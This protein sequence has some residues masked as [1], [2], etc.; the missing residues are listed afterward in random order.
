MIMIKRVSR[1]LGLT[2]G[3]LSLMVCAAF[4][5]AQG[6]EPE[7]VVVG[8]IAHVEGQLLRYVPDDQD[9]VATVKNAPFGLDDALYSDD[10]S[11]AEFIMPNG[12]W[13]RIEAGTQMQLLTLDEDVTEVDVASGVARFYNKSPDT[14]IKATTPFGYILAAGGTGFDLYVGDESME[15]IALQGN[16]DFVHVAGD[17]KYEVSADGASI[18]ADSQ[19]VSSGEGT[20]DA[21]WDAWNGDRDSLWSKRV[22]VRGDSVEQLPEQL[23]DD[24]YTLEEAGKWEEVEYEGARRRLWRPVR[25]EAGWA[26]FTAGRWT[27]WGGDNCSGS[28]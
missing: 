26:P 18:L 14:V 11:R 22:Q 28:R 8:R 23:R 27:E 10:N 20:V 12:T 9:W 1:W 2:G 15:V 3:L 24:A 6:N 17:T 19:Q 21:D 7:N 13:V 16:V 25:V 4:A 5:Q